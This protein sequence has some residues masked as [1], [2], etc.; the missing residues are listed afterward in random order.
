V[1][2]DGR[3]D[4]FKDIQS[5]AIPVACIAMCPSKSRIE[6]DCE[7]SESSLELGQRV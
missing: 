2:I 3:S 5:R 1:L 6:T 7:Q 4:G